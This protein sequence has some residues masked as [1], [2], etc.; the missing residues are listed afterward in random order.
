MTELS[1]FLNEKKY[2]NKY[3]GQFVKIKNKNY[4]TGSLLKKSTIKH[5]EEFLGDGVIID[6]DPYDNKIVDY[7]IKRNFTIFYVTGKKPGSIE[8]NISNN[9]IVQGTNI[10]IEGGK[11]EIL[12]KA[13]EETSGKKEQEI[14]DFLTKPTYSNKYIGKRFHTNSKINSNMVIQGTVISVE[15]YDFKELGLPNP[16][17]VLVNID[18]KNGMNTYNF[19]KNNFDNIDDT[20]KKPSPDIGDNYNNLLKIKSL[21]EKE[22]NEKEKELKSIQEDKGE[23][24]NPYIGKR[25]S[26]EVKPGIKEN[27]TVVSTHPNE[28]PTELE[29]FYDNPEI[30]K[31]KIGFGNKY[32]LNTD[33]IKTNIDKGIFRLASNNT[34]IH[35]N[36]FQNN[37]GNILSYISEFSLKMMPNILYKIKKLIYQK[38]KKKEQKNEEET[39]KDEIKKE[40][41]KTDEIKKEQKK[42]EQT[43][44][45][46]RKKKILQNIKLKSLLKKMI[47]KIK[48]E[49]T[50]LQNI[51]NFIKS[52]DSGYDEESESCKLNNE[53][54]EIEEEEIGKLTLKVTPYDVNDGVNSKGYQ[55]ADYRLKIDKKPFTVF[56]KIENL[57]KNMFRF[58]KKEG[59]F[60]PVFR[61]DGNDRELWFYKGKQPDLKDYI[62][63]GL[64]NPKKKDTSL[65]DIDVDLE[66]ENIDNHEKK[67]EIKLLDE[68]GWYRQPITLKEFAEERI[69]L[70]EDIE[71]DLHPIKEKLVSVEDI[72]LEIKEANETIGGKKTRNRKKT[73][74]RMSKKNRH[75]KDL[76]FEFSI[77]LVNRH[78]GK[79]IKYWKIRKRTI[80]SRPLKIPRKLL[81][82]FTRKNY[83]QSPHSKD[84]K[85]VSKS[86]NL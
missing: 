48:N 15:P 86:Y 20:N 2:L 73:P 66:N 1:N 3:I 31:S 5:E 41:L 13:I 24:N 82:Q 11:I 7:K 67:K 76:T 23:Y 10:Q 46:E 29:I 69:L 56:D 8:E 52:S 39:K 60:T 74:R 50:L 12:K 54:A 38:S 85:F 59:S 36:E 75:S 80:R 63:E 40:Q 77:F 26:I 44:K 37:K 43:K 33:I 70:N 58:E 18:D 57:L 81:Y 17:K 16:N 27:G 61:V 53:T 6:T 51:G 62:R 32:G 28:S 30:N 4:H 55:I 21:I 34:L 71:I 83:S 14:K 65:K 25:V 78:K 49:K 84:H 72:A 64:I 22:T 9:D 35:F 79:P 19:D 47:D 45:D 68:K 42:K